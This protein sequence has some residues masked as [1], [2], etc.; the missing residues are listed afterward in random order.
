MFAL[1]ACLLGFDNKWANKKGPMGLQFE[2][3]ETVKEALG[4]SP[5]VLLAEWLYD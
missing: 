3:I 4:E 5:V 1:D 2:A